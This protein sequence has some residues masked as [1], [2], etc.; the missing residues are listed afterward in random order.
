MFK[1]L[2]G[3]FLA[4]A[5][6]ALTSVCTAWAVIDFDNFD[7]KKDWFKLIVIGLPALGGYMS[8]INKPKR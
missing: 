8:T 6:G 5:A 1:K 4:T 2:N 7:I 3:N